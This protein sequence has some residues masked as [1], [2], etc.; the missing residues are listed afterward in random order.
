MPLMLDTGGAYVPTGDDSYPL[1][2]IDLCDWEDGHGPK[3]AITVP[4]YFETNRGAY[5]GDGVMSL[6]LNVV[7][8]HYLA[9]YREEDGGAG[10][11][12]FCKYLRDYAD[13]LQASL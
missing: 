13:R 5:V 9:N 8:E 12:D 2:D 11:P 1:F 4:A 10:V 7:L 3:L 6:P